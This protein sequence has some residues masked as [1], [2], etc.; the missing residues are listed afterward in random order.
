MRAAITGRTEIGVAAIVI[1]LVDVVVFLPIAFI[2][3][4]IGHQLAEFADRRRDR[5]PD[6]AVRVLHDHA[7]AGRELGPQV[8]LA[9]RGGS[10]SSSRAASTR[11]ATGTRTS[12]CRGGCGTRRSSS[13]SACADRS[14]AR[15]RWC[16]WASS[17]RSSSRR[18]TAARSSSSCSIPLGTPLA[19]TTQACWRSSADSQLARTSM[20]TPRSPARMPRRSAVSSRKAT[21]GRSTSGCKTTARIHR[22]TG[23][24][25]FRR[26]RAAVRAG[27]RIRWSFRR[28]ASAGGNAAQPLDEL[29]TDI[30]GGDPTPYAK[31][32]QAALAETPGATNIISS[33]QAL[34]PQVDVIFDRA[35]AQALNVTIGTAATAAR[36]AFGGA[37]ATQFETPDGLE[38]VQVIYP[39]QLQTNFAELANVPIRNNA[40]QI[41]HLGD[42]SHFKVDP[43]AAAHHARSTATPSSTSARTSRPARRSRTCR[44]RSSRA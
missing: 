22:P 44:T 14:S 27:A 20:R 5:D 16:R 1:T 35:K 4:Q 2:Q 30:T 25:E 13:A 24:R 31:K 6:L 11:R 36:A 29:V 28:P 42:F 32:I 9:A 40:G 37:I 21:S 19:H 17:A 15:W 18:R 43:V 34:E 8:D 26:R 33:S 12:R 41:V 7:V 38:Q 23:S 39:R 10:S 3:S